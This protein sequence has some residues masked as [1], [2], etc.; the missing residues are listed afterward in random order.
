MRI[1]FRMAAAMLLGSVLMT[2]AVFALNLE[3][4]RR[5]VYRELLKELDKD[6]D[7]KIGK[8]EYM[9]IWKDRD[10][11]EANYVHFD[12]NKDGFITEEEYIK[13]TELPARKK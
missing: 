11:G 6:R 1:V 4:R 8:S 12:Q 9:A 3:E 2:T 7:G 10:Y 5:M 13:K